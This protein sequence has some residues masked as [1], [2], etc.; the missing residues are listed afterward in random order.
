MGARVRLHQIVTNLVSNALKFTPASGL[1][2]IRLESAGDF[3]RLAVKD[4]GCGIEPWLIGEIFEPFVQGERKIAGAGG[5][6]L[7]LSIAKLLIEL[8]KG[9]LRAFSEG[10]GQGA[11]FV[12]D[13]PRAK[14]PPTTEVPYY[15]PAVT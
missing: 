6:G 11:T 1:I 13:L 9:E 12:V 15:S 14:Q 7:G 2:T 5:M 8:H 3:V 10:V 4:N